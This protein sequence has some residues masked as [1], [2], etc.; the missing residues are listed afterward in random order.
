[1]IEAFNEALSDFDLLIGSDIYLTNL[2][3]QPEISVPHGFY[4][5]GLPTTLRLTGKLFGE[6]EILKVAHAFQSKTDYHL[7]HPMLQ[8]G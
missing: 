4:T 6:T 1:M 8:S 3:G 7:K 5:E 2:T